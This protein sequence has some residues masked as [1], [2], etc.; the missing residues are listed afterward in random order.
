M[1]FFF[2]FFF[3]FFYILYIFGIHCKKLAKGELWFWI[4][5]T[6]IGCVDH[7]CFWECVKHK[8][9]K[10]NTREE[11]LIKRFTSPVSRNAKNEVAL[12]YFVRKTLLNTCTFEEEQYLVY[13]LQFYQNKWNWWD[14][15]CYLKCLWFNNR[16]SLDIPMAMQKLLI[17]KL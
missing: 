14:F 17:S 13:S 2:V 12:D 5:K 6:K 11:Y 15:V 10:Y 16:S 8:N 7:Q 9:V 3:Y 1:R 4:W